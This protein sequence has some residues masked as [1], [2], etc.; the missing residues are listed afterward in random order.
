MLLAYNSI[1]SIGGITAYLFDDE[2]EI[3]AAALDLVA[4]TVELDLGSLL[5]TRLDGYFEDLVCLDAL[6]RLVICLALDLHLLRDAVEQLFESEWQRTLDSCDFRRRLAASAIRAGKASR[7]SHASATR[8]RSSTA[9]TAK[10][11]EDVGE[12]I[13]IGATTAAA[14]ALAHELCKDVLG[15][16]EVEASRAAAEVEGPGAATSTARHAFKTIEASKAARHAAGASIWVAFGIGGR[17]AAAAEKELETKLVIDLALFGVGQ[18]LIG[19]RTFFELLGSVG[20][21]LVLVGVPL[22][23]GLSI[24]R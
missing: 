21:V 17:G 3:L 23:S 7:R 9:G 12:I 2:V 6:A 15:V 10:R 22:Q 16:V 18:D 14:A 24:S 20:V 4:H 19:L 1:I 8:T 13:R 11:R 5:Q